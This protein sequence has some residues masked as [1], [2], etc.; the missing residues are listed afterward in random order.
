MELAKEGKSGNSLSACSGNHNLNAKKLNIKQ[1]LFLTDWFLS[2][3]L[4][5]GHEAKGG[6]AV[7][8][9]CSSP[10]LLFGAV[11]GPKGLP[12][13][14]G[15]RDKV[16]WLLCQQKMPCE[17]VCQCKQES[18]LINMKCVCVFRDAGAW[19]GVVAPHASHSTLSNTATLQQKLFT[20]ELFDFFIFLLKLHNEIV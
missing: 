12:P 1:K 9:C 16:K 8:Q 14:E 11:R 10:N 18:W 20:W 6:A 13:A 4:F 15:G 19:S 5:L 2:Y 3:W 17:N 7:S